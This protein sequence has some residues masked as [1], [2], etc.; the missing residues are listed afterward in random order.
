MAVDLDPSNYYRGLA[1]EHPLYHPNRL[2]ELAIALR[3]QQGPRGSKTGGVAAQ[4]AAHED[5]VICLTPL[6]WYMHHGNRLNGST[7]GVEVSGLYPG[8][9]DDPTTPPREDLKTLWGDEQ[10]ELTEGRILA[11]RAAVRYAVVEGRQLGM[12]IRY[13]YAHRQS[14]GNK[15]GDPGEGLWRAVVTDYAVPKLGLE[16]RYDFTLDK[17]RPIPTQWDENGVGDY[18]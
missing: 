11:A 13:I 6:D 10:T 8:L 17:G 12:P 18:R 14:N 15:P 1:K 4:L 2:D 9:L 3:A 16:V 5:F 7:I